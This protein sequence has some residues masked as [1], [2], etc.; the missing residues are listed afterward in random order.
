[1][2]SPTVRM[3]APPTTEAPRTTE[4]CP[5]CESQMTVAQV[6]PLLFANDLESVTY[7]CTKCGLELERTFHSPSSKPRWHRGGFERVR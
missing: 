4:V 3:G 1:M 7:T 6:M 5:N 2:T